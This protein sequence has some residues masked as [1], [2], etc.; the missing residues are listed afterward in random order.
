LGNEDEKATEP[1]KPT[2]TGKP[3]RRGAPKK[4]EGIDWL[5]VKT[6]YVTTTYTCDQ[7]AEKYDC[8]LNAVLEHSRK[9]GWVKARKKYQNERGKRT[10]AAIQRTQI[11]SVVQ[12]VESVSALA[13]GVMQRL[14]Q[15]FAAR[16]VKR[17]T[18]P[19]GCGHAFEVELP[20]TDIS[21]ADLAQLIKIRSHLKGDPEFVVRVE[22]EEIPEELK[23]MSKEELEEKLK[24]TLVEAEA[25]V[26]D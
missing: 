22:K 15:K 12:E 4:G 23:K 1:I 24:E 7:L 21:V 6:L 25:F 17:V 11:R 2:Q 20:H 18:C 3:R 9:E 10:A 13:Q 16:N 14:A 19:C 5:E 8:S 26:L